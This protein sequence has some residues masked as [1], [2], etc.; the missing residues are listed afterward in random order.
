MAI[1][2]SYIDQI[3][4]EHSNAKRGTKGA[5]VKRWADY[6][7]CSVNTVWAVIKTGRK[8]KRDEAKATVLKEVTET[9]YQVKNRVPDSTS[10]LSTYQAL[11]IAQENTLFPQ[12]APSFSTS[13]IDKM[14]NR[15]G[16]NKKTRRVQ[17]FQA[18]RPNQMHHVDASSSQFFYVDR[19]LPNGEY[20]LKLHKPSKDYKNKPI[21]IQLRPWIYGLADDYSGVTLARYTV[22]PGESMTDNLKFLEWAWSA[23]DDKPFHG[24]PEMVK[25]DKGPMVRGKATEELFDRMGIEI[26]PSVPGAKDAHG[27]VERPWRTLWQCFEKQFLVIDD[28]QDWEITLSELNRRL[29]IYLQEDYNE[30]SHRNETKITRAQAWSKI[31]LTGGIKPL[32]NGA[33]ATA[34]KKT[35]RT[36]GADGVFSL[37]NKKYEVKGLH[38]AKV[39]VIESIFTGEMIVQDIATGKKYEVEDFKPN[40]IGEFTAHPDTPHQ[41]IVK[42]GKDLRITKTLFEVEK[43]A[44]NVIPL[45]PRVQEEQQFD[46]VFAGNTHTSLAAAMT[47]FMVSTGL[48]P[49]EGSEERASL[50]QL[51]VE[52]KLC[53]SFVREIADQVI[54]ANGTENRRYE[55]G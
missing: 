15:L 22:A 17:R 14:A 28:Y 30:R 20:I 23:T 16:L 42:A 32:P 25:A 18:D 26:D 4:L 55:H 11:K 50:E 46:K 29:M 35:K 6:L 37:D 41:K 48:F 19:M 36:V 7:E 21:P 38:A 8:R 33:F 2:Q 10:A 3:R 34:H 49:E 13:S 39:D 5:V 1:K 47:E 45:P 12:G 44:S 52:H 40:A 24:L 27:K 53:K 51:F 31:S 43:E 54:L 9:V